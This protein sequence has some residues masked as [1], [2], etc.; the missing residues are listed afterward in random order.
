M[1][2]VR[3][4]LEPIRKLAHTSVMTML[5][6]MTD[7]GQ[8]TRAKQGA[9]Y[10]YRARIRLDQTLRRMLGDLVER[11]FDGSAGAAVLQL[12]ET[13][14]LSPKEIAEVRALLGRKTGEDAS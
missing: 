8:V 11:A 7:K 9:G 13:G 6:I 14:D 3:E 10:V 4:R 5:G 12:L 2:E 1:R